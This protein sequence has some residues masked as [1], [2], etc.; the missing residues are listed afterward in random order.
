MLKE[1]KNKGFKKKKV[2]LERD[3]FKVKNIKQ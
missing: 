1:Q 3:I 2:L